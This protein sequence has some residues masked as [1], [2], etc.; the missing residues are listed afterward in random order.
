MKT[1]QPAACKK[2]KIIPRIPIFI[3]ISLLCFYCL[4]LSTRFDGYERGFFQTALTAV[5]QHEFYMGGGGMA[6]TTVIGGKRYAEYVLESILDIPLVGA[7]MA[8]DSLFSKAGMDPQLVFFLP[9][10]LNALLT[11]LT[12]MLLYLF[13]LRIYNSERTAVIIAFVYGLTTQALPYATIGMDPLFVFL[14]VLGFYLIRRGAD[15]DGTVVFA[16]AGLVFGLAIGAKTYAFIMY[17]FAAFYLYLLNREKKIEGL[18]L[19]LALIIGG[20]I[21]GFIPYFWYNYIRF[22]T[23]VPFG[24]SASI[25]GAIF[26]P[27]LVSFLDN[28]YASFLSAGKSFFLYSPPLIFIFWAVPRFF[29]KSRTDA[30]VLLSLCLAFVVFFC[31]TGIWADEVWGTRYFLVIVPF[32]TLM[33]GVIIEGLK[34]ARRPAKF[35]FYASL[36]LGFLVQ[37]PGT[38]VYYGNFT[39]ILVK[40]KL[41]SVQN[42]FYIPELSHL[43]INIF[44]MWATL[45]N[46]FTGSFPAYYYYPR[47]DIPYML[48]FDP[49]QVSI[50]PGDY[51]NVWWHQVLSSP[52]IEGLSKFL[53]ILLAIS[54]FAGFFIFGIK[55]YRMTAPDKKPR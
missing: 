33:I 26:Q 29:R 23:I 15:G 55:A 48:K 44:L 12:A 10:G 24:R 18:P 27:S 43:R 31:M 20:G 8:L 7:G 25:A 40:N 32:L 52:D 16:L 38:F 47:S 37:I 54:L 6:G 53:V 9:K 13:A 49:I 14:A 36:V 19:K 50:E 11:A 5:T 21:I 30:L 41:Y 35:A 51:I 28:L 45:Q 22:G 46:I 3:F 34:N 4:V 17:P 42:A 1:K 39:Q 2:S